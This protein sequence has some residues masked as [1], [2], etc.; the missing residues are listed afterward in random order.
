[1][2]ARRRD[3]PSERAASSRLGG[4]ALDHANKCQDHEGHRELNQ[5]ENHT[6]KVIHQRDRTIRQPHALE[7][8]G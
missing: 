3:A 7:E 1:M 5:S 8:S 2:N 4:N 6:A